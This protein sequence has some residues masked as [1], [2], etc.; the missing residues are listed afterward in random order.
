MIRNANGSPRRFGAPTSS[1]NPTKGVAVL[2]LTLTGCTAAPAGPPD[3]PPTTPSPFTSLALPAPDQPGPKVTVQGDTSWDIPKPG[4]AVVRLAAGQAFQLTGPEVE[5]YL[6][7]VRSG[8]AP[9][10]Q[11]M[12]LTGH[13]AKVGA[14]VC[15]AHRAFVVEKV[16]STEE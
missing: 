9:G 15:G 10:R 14:S 6:A 13:L 2:L 8:A 7:D 3:A 5:R 16:S 1:V 12:R 4:C 11:R